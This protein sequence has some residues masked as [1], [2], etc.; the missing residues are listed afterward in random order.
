[1]VFNRY[2]ERA[3]HSKNSR[4]DTLCHNLGLEDRRFK[5]KIETI[6][7]PIDY[8]IVYRKLNVLRNKANTYLDKALGSVS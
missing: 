7:Q 5:G 2:A 8:D 3:K 4:I 6:T 1:M